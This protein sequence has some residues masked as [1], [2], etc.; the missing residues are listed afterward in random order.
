[1]RWMNIRLCGGIRGCTLYSICMVEAQ[2]GDGD[3]QAGRIAR[4]ER[5][6]AFSRPDRADSTLTPFYL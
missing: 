2:F 4:Y 3:R 1:M 6:Q 5:K